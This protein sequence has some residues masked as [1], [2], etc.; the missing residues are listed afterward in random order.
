MCIYMT[1]KTRN[2]IQVNNFVILTKLIA[3]NREMTVLQCEINVDYKIFKKK[4][5]I[6]SIVFAIVSLFFSSFN[7]INDSILF[8]SIERR[9]E[10][11]NILATIMEKFDSIFFR[12]W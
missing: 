4:I 6:F 9:K 2:R 10:K 5:E 8:N 11:K 3:K 7:N 1:K 12:F